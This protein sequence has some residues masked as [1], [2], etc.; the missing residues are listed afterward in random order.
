M[1]GLANTHLCTCSLAARRPSDVE[2]PSAV[3]MFTGHRNSISGCGDLNERA[4]VASSISLA[5]T[6][7]N[8]IEH[9]YVRAIRS[10]R[11]RLERR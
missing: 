1:Q 11:T 9:A 8:N 10:A 4:C 2:R 3:Q 6:G 5:L 7:G